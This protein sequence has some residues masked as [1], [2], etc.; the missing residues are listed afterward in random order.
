MKMMTYNHSMIVKN[1]ESQESPMDYQQHIEI[2]AGKRSGKACIKNTRIS[3]YD[4]LG[5]L[6]S[7]LSSQE[8]VEDYPELTI[9]NVQA[10]L[11]YAAEREHR[12]VTVAA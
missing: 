7:G 6:A 3:V 4:V 8:I 11:A 9:E 2:I 1:T 10:C 12:L 5:W